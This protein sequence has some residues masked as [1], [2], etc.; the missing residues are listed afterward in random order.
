MEVKTLISPEE[1][2][3]KERENPNKKFEYLDGNLI[4]M[5]GS[6]LKH[7]RLVK[8][9]LIAL[10]SRLANNGLYEALVSDIRVH[11]PVS[12]SYF[13]PDVVVLP[14]PPQLL[15]DH[16]DTVTNP[17]VIIEVLSDSTAD[18]DK[19][20]KFSAYQTIPSLQEYILI[21][22]K[23]V[24]LGIYQRLSEREW[25][26]TWFAELEAALPLPSLSLE[27]PLSEIYKGV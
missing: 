13:Y 23:E 8:N 21:S 25:K 5:S 16:F 17:R 1:Y 19:G 11:N 22:Q 10:E 15:D 2:L 9:L 18:F 26:Y 6:S 3:L 7:N 14:N 4:E 24:K 27:I 20:E 12:N